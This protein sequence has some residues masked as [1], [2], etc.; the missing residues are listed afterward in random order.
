MGDLDKN[1]N[2][3]YRIH[4]DDKV[5]IWP[6]PF[7]NEDSFGNP[8]QNLTIETKD[9]RHLRVFG[10]TFKQLASL[11]QQIGEVLGQVPNA[12]LYHLT[13]ARKLLDELIGE[14]RNPRC[15]PTDTHE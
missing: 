15:P 3:Q 1:C 6:S 2:H 7:D 10:L 11:Y 13:Q 5:Q 12:T 8:R 14:E 9:G 4:Q